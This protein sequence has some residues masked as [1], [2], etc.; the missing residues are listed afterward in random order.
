MGQGTQ[1]VL[2]VRGLCPAETQA[3]LS[4]GLPKPPKCAM[5]FLGATPSSPPTR[6]HVLTPALAHGPTPA[7]SEVLSVCATAAQRGKQSPS[8]V[9]RSTERKFVVL[10]ERLHTR[11]QA[12]HGLAFT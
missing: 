3:R 2:S 9:M 11:P 8:T 10:T 12:V 6:L 4:S 5:R 7:P 1:A